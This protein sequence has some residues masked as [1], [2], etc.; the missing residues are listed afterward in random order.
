[1]NKRYLWLYIL[2]SFLCAFTPS[3][4][5]QTYGLKFQG[6]NVTLDKRTELN[7]TPT[8]F[9]NFNDEF[10][11][12]FDIKFDLIDPNCLFGYI[13]RVINQ[14]N[15]NVD[16]ISTPDPAAPL[17][18]VIG[19]N[20]EVV[21]VSQFNNSN[22]Q[23]NNLRLKFMLSQNRLVFYLADT[24]YVHNDI[25][26]KKQDAFKIIFGAND[27]EQFNTTDVPSMNIKDVKISEKGILKYHWLL[28]AKEGTDV[29][30][31]IRNEKASVKNPVW[32]V[33]KH[34]TWQLAYETEL[35]GQILFASDEQNGRIFL[36]NNNELQIYSADVEEVTIIEYKNPPQFFTNSYR[37]IFNS[38]NGKIYCY[39]PD[40]TTIYSLD[41]ETGVWNDT[42]TTSDIMTK[43]RHHNRH[44][45]PADNSI[46]IF[47]GYGVH[48]YNNIIR[49]LNLDTNTLQD[50]PTN[51]S[52]FYPRYLAGLGELKDTIYI[53]GGYG[54]QTGNQLI[55]P[56]NYY[57]LIGYS[58][59]DSSLFR[60]FEVPRIMDDMI[61]ANSMW[62][63][64]T[65]R[66]YYALI[67]KKTRFDG[68][69]QL[70]KG[71]IDFP[72]IE[73]LGN[74]IP[75]KFLDIRSYAGLLF[76]PE[77]N[78][79]FAITSY[80]TDS[81]TTQAQV[82]SINYPINRHVVKS[83]AKT[84]S[85]KSKYIVILA[86]VLFAAI[87][88]WFLRLRKKEKTLVPEYK[89]NDSEEESISDDSL[90]SYIENET[91]AYQLVFFGGF[92]VFNSNHEDITSKFSPLLKELFLLIL[93]HSYK[94]NKGISSESI[95]EILWFGKSEKSAR[96]NRAVNIAKL[97][98]L[99]EEIGNCELTKKTGY[100][101]IIFED[102][103]VKCDYVDFLNIT[104]SKNNLTKYKVSQLI[105]I[106]QK[107]GFLSHANYGWLDEFKAS[108]S[109]RI[110]E[111]LVDFGQKADIKAEA[112]F[113]IP[114]TDCIF[115]FDIVNEEA[116]LLKCRAQYCMGKH[117]H[118]KATYDKFSK[119]Y[120]VM[121]NQEYEKSF[122]EILEIK[123]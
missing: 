116:M 119:E 2:F 117:S 11:V 7:L 37:A 57:D 61:V 20:N 94:N 55:N 8:D 38:S 12:S 4:L 86:L 50:L 66:N 28:D 56:H 35:K 72:E 65:T 30:D 104:S 105:D 21:P 74:M 108:V 32:L 1:M 3:V 42:T 92:Q 75:F 83:E 10:E 82:F 78:K 58:I 17:N 54:S 76:M 95:T 22:N 36:V 73:M 91:P 15:I 46:Y 39:L 77:Q 44:Y 67:F 110:V 84:K 123:E 88:V 114:L 52:I 97:R 14:E 81:T 33:H 53:L 101:K 85:G 109:D 118:A 71:N 102:V 89:L 48:K 122:L 31:R 103:D 9:L 107:G 99:L 29:Y 120:L 6:Q 18:L 79:L 63:D 69:L 121:Y 115:N 98:S 23:W 80:V 96:N 26:F 41:I 93:L 5:G 112:D 100:W 90:P 59:K 49:K 45:N 60:K 47:G 25:G 51:D 13:F 64:K 113:V 68:N 40:E 70:I 19:K 16:L 111:T 62:I 34:D 24:F 106:A 87:L 27:Y 43:Y